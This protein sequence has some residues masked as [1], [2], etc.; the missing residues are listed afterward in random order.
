MDSSSLFFTAQPMSPVPSRNFSYVDPVPSR[1]FT[2]VDPV[3]SRNFTYVDPVPSR[4][5]TYE[6]FEF[7]THVKMFITV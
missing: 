6:I 3:P 1:N 2:Y 7:K 4:N 5:F